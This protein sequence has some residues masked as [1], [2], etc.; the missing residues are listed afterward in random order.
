LDFDVIAAIRTS[1]CAEEPSST[2]LLRRAASSSVTP[3]VAPDNAEGRRANAIRSLSETGYRQGGRYKRIF[4]GIDHMF[5]A[6]VAWSTWRLA[7]RYGFDDARSRRRALRHAAIAGWAAGS[8]PPSES[9][10][11]GAALNGEF[12]SAFERGRNMYLAAR[13]KLN[14]KGD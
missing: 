9:L 13:E 11:Y 2:K 10:L 6:E 14:K 5:E 7:A 8:W 3:Q 4:T 1:D 12:A